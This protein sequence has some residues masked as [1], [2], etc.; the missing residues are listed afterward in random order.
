MV[1]SIVRAVFYLL[2]IYVFRYII[3]TKY[4]DKRIALDLFYG[5]L[6][7]IL[8]MMFLDALM[9]FGSIGL[10]GEHFPLSFVVGNLGLPVVAI[11]SAV[12]IVVVSIYRRSWWVVLGYFFGGTA[13]SILG[14]VPS[15]LVK[16]I[17]KG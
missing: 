10:S 16:V 8:P 15:L 9:I 14:Y 6:V 3:R 1:I 11:L 13:F 17:Y 12:G 4:T 2:G 5:T 7:Y